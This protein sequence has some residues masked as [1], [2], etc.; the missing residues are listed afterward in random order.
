MLNLLKSRINHGNQAIK[1]VKKAVLH[2]RYAGFPEL[3]N[4]ECNNCFRCTSVCPTGA[5]TAKQLSLDL[6]K[7]I[8]CR[9]CERAC[10][11][12]AIKF[13]NF[14]KTA[15]SVRESLIVTE[16]TTIVDYEKRAF[17][18]N[19]KIKSVFGNSLKLRSVSAGGCNACELELN[20]SGNVNFD[21][22]RFGIDVVASPRHAD[23]VIITGP[24][25]KNM[26]YAL[27]ETF[28]SSSDPKII[29]LAGACAISGGM[30]A[31]SEAINRE[32]LKKYKA[33]LFIPGCPFHPLTLINGILGLL[34]K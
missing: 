10:K 1:D 18:S 11:S 13:D 27:E 16:K 23:G 22:G 30:F 24:I 28:L 15:A 33:N 3:K 25:T 7:C 32:F 29:I 34:G 14:H 5:I 9:D 20:A 8:F 31:D 19:K 12:G 17:Q 26:A 6:G 21:M 4:K 2:N